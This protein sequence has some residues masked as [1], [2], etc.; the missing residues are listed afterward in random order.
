MK[1]HKKIG[2]IFLAQNTRLK[3]RLIPWI[4][5]TNGCVWLASMAVSLSNRQIN[6]WMN[7]RKNKRVRQLDS[8]LTGKFGPKA[9]AF[10]IRQVRKWILELPPG[11]SICL[12]CE[13]AVPDKQFQI[14]KNWFLRHEDSK[15]EISDEHQS[16]FFYKSILVE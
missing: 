12:K 3:L 1:R 9:Q 13:S 4:K 16:F 10:A 11:D 14:W 8:S 6:D 5:T 7:R 15:W 2:T